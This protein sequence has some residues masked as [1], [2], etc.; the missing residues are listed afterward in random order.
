MAAAKNPSRPHQD[1]RTQ[2]T[3]NRR[4]DA[5]TPPLCVPPPSRP[6]TRAHLR[7]APRPVLHRAQQAQHLRAHPLALSALCAAGRVGLHYRGE[8]RFTG[9]SGVAGIGV[10]STDSWSSRSAECEEIVH[11]KSTR[12]ALYEIV[13]PGVNTWRPCISP[14]SHPSA[15][16]TLIANIQVVAGGYFSSE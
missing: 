6:A 15:S 5:L 8:E 4:N 2:P 12:A 10:G 11:K 13:P 16:S 1:R 7:H 14:S 9:S 3:S